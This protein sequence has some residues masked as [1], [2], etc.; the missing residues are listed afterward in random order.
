MKEKDIGYKKIKF[1]LFF[2]KYSEF[3][4]NRKKFLHLT[5]VTYLL[6]KQ[7]KIFVKLINIQKLYKL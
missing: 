5:P 2:T 7:N 4:F 6:N 1:F 3:L